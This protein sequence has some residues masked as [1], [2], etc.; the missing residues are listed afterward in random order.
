MALGT[1]STC[2]SFCTCVCQPS[3]QA[4]LQ[5]IL[6][7]HIDVVKNLRTFLAVVSDTCSTLCSSG[8]NKRSAIGVNRETSAVSV[9]FLV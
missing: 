9:I 5:L 3:K 1:E 7:R 8:E 4:E 2:S 6:I